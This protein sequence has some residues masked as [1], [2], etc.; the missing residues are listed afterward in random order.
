M[1]CRGSLRHLHRVVVRETDDCVHLAGRQGRLLRVADRRN[2]HV[3]GLQT[4]G[5]DRREGRVVARAIL[6]GNAN[7]LALQVCE[8]RDR[9]IRGNDD[10]AGVEALGGKASNK[11]LQVVDVKTYIDII[12]QAVGKIIDLSE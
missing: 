7:R 12:G 11:N 9:R 1:D 4:A 8:G 2:S 3:G 5:L 10:S 6:A